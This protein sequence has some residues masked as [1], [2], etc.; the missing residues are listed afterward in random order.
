M[1]TPAEPWPDFYS[2]V[3][4]YTKYLEDQEDEV[5][6][7]PILEAAMDMVAMAHPVDAVTREAGEVYARFLGDQLARWLDS[8]EQTVEALR[9]R[10][11]NARGLLEG[12]RLLFRDAEGP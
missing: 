5:T 6:F 10:A 3:V 12:A 7:N 2:L 1:T 9:S 8:E 4:L 11:E